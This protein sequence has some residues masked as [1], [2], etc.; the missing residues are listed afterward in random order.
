PPARQEPRAAI[1]VATNLL[2]AHSRV[3][4]RFHA[5]TS[6]GEIGIVLNM[7]PVKPA[8]DDPA[9][10][11]A[12]HLADAVLNRWFIDP[13]LHGR[14]PEAAVSL[15]ERCGM[16]P[17]MEPRDKQRVEHPSADFLGVNY[18]Y[19]HHASADAE[20]TGF[21]LN[22]TGTRD[23]PCKF[24]IKG[25]FRFVQPAQNRATDWGWEIA[26]EELGSLLLALHRERP[27]LPIDITEN[28]IG[29]PD[30]P[31]PDG[32]VNDQT[33]I[34][35]VRDHLIA[36]HR[37]MAAGAK[38]RG[39]YHWSLLDNFSWINGFKKRYGFFH[40]DRTT[41]ER[42]PKASAFWY[43]TVSKNHGF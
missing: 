13:V 17:R 3:Y 6:T 34:E 31:G 41:M 1:Q 10:I 12:A 33:R 22:T 4:E 26:P 18:Y 36:I 8:T 20:E 16:M 30:V 29:Q 38:V 14:F 42:H 24:A 7:S 32:Q 35:F 40:V 28:G 19:P 21:H 2:I 9:D 11:H 23:E 37:A 15:Y 43:R 27:D 39:Y 5:G 25:L